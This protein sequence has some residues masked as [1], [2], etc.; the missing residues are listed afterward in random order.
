MLKDTLTFGTYQMNHLWMTTCQDL[1]TKRKLLAGKE[2]NV[3]RKRWFMLDPYKAEVIL[4]EH[5][6]THHLPNGI[7]RKTLEDRTS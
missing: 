4:K 7:L 5:W 6:M 2:I 3:K 1:K